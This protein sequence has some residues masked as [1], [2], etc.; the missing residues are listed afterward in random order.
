M[1]AFKKRTI[2]FKKLKICCHAKADAIHLFREVAL[3]TEDLHLKMKA[4]TRNVP[5]KDIVK[6][7]K[8]SEVIEEEH[9]HPNKHQKH[10]HLQ[11]RRK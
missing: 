11:T 3:L 6:F 8:W 1:I 9:Y 7:S 5:V 4:H 2:S 10:R